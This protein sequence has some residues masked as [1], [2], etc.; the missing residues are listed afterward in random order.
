MTLHSFSTQDTSILYIVE[1]SLA[2]M[3]KLGS[4]KWEVNFNNQSTKSLVVR[5]LS[6]VDWLC[7]EANDVVSNIIAWI[8][9][10]LVP[11]RDSGC[12]CIVN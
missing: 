6:I 7:C 1:R 2:W 11:F 8:V 9:V 4:C 3:L 12:I 5:T 10:K